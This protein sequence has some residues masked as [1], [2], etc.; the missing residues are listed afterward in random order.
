MKFILAGFYGFFNY[1]IT[2]K[3]E[4][5]TEPF[6]LY[7]NNWAMESKKESCSFERRS[8]IRQCRTAPDGSPF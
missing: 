2:K 8:G 1:E 6:Y 5:Q 4:K 3:P 7:A